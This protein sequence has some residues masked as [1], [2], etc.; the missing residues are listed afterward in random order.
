[1]KIFGLAIIFIII[2]GTLNGIIPFDLNDGIKYIGLD[3]HYEHY[4]ATIEGPNPVPHGAAYNSYVII[5][6]KI[7]IVEGI[8]EFYLNKWLEKLEKAL[9]GRNPDYILIHHME[10]DH[11]G[12]LMEL[13]KRYPKI[14]VISSSKSFSMMKNFFGNDFADRRIV[15]KEGD[16][17]ELGKHVLHIIEAPMI[18]WPEVII[19]YDSFTKSL[20]S[21][22]IFGKFG[23]NDFDEPWDDEGR[24]FYFGILSIYG[25][26]V[27]TLLKKLSKIEIRNIYPGHG[28]II[29]ENI[30]HY[31]SLYDK[32]SK[33][34]PEEEGVVIVYSSIY[35]HTKVAVD[36]LA[37]KLSSLKVKYSIHDISKSHWTNI[38]AEAYKYS[39]LVLA[40]IMVDDDISPSMKEFIEILSSF[41]YQNRKVGFMENGSWNPKSNRIMKSLLANCKNLEFFKNSVTINVS[42][43]EK[44][45]S[46]INALASEI[47]GIKK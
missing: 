15:V 13:I 32:W 6:E 9:E 28:Q 21:C 38:I 16:K 39:S 35:G 45:I 5:D 8:H 33:Y 40:S 4:E 20:F 44:S 2:K 26:Q 22:D 41:H 46:Q 18:H 10:P 12:N 23:A 30:D 34:I 3:D 1:M 43:N 47:A 29:T 36:K 17:I 25:G 31:I 27:Q 42:L 37:E 11:S 19:S 14:K 7:L 24:R